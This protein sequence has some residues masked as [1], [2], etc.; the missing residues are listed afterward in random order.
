MVLQ[1]LDELLDFIGTV[2]RNPDIEDPAVS[3]GT[4][5]FH[6]RCSNQCM[7]MGVYIYI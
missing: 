5:K 4:P 6:S 3:A 1:S 2:S 7:Y